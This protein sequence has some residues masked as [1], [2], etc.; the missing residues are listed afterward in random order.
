MRLAVEINLATFL[1]CNL[2][3]FCESG[4]LDR[5][6]IVSSLER[7][8]FSERISS[9]M[10]GLWGQDE[11]VTDLTGACLSSIVIRVELKRSR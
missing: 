8:D 7:F 4:V 5:R 11:Q 6:Y 9:V 2:K 3:F 1:D 10:N